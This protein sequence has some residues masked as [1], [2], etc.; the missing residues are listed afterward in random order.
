MDPPCKG[1]ALEF[2]ALFYET[3]PIEARRSAFK[4]EGEHGTGVGQEGEG[5]SRGEGG[6]GRPKLVLEDTRPPK[7]IVCES[8]INS[9][10]HTV[11]CSWICGLS[12]ENCICTLHKLTNFVPLLPAPGHVAGQHASGACTLPGTCMWHSE[13]ICEWLNEWSPQWTLFPIS[14]PGG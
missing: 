5:G 8:C 1:K 4:A 13:N 6:K 2:T 9:N 12:S 3:L 11:V 14:G 7:E 10:V